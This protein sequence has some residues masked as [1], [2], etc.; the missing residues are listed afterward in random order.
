MPRRLVYHDLSPEITER[1]AVFPGDTPFSREVALDFARGDHL[2]LS[3]LRTTAHVGAHADAPSHYHPRGAGI[4]ERR[5]DYYLGRAQVLHVE[6]PRGERIRP[7]HLGGRE[8]RAPRV[9]FRTGSF[10]DPNRWSGDFNSLSPELVDALAGQGV[11]LVGIDTPSVDP[12]ASK[13]LESHQAIFRHD[14]AVLEGIVLDQVPEGV[15]RLVALPLRLKGCDASPVR[16]VL[17]E[18]ESWNQS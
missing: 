16:A 12:E 15:Y 4:A 5:L 6:L 11:I 1:I 2:G 18:E 8:I 7:A 17:V 9:L 14:M 3:S 13:A 10:P